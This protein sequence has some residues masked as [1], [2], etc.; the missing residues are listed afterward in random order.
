MTTLL[1][2]KVV[3]TISQKNSNYFESFRN[4]LEQSHKILEDVVLNI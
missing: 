3:Q 4:N 1:I 2:K